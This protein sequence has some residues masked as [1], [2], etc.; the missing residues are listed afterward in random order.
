LLKDEIAI[1]DIINSNLYDRP[2]YWA[3][4]CQ[5]SKLMGLE[6]YLELE[7]LG[8]KL[9]VTQNPSDS[10]NY[11]IIGSG[12]INTDK[13]ADL[14]M[15]TWQWGN[16][17]K[18]DTHISS[19]YQPA[20]QSMQIVIM[21]TMEA[22]MAEGKT[23]EALAVGDKYFAAFPDMNFPFFYQTYLMLQPYFQANQLER[24]QPILEQLARNT[25]DRLDY[26]DTLDETRKRNS[27]EG[28]V[29][30]AEAIAR[31]MLQQVR[32]RGSEEIKASIEQIL[33]NH[34]YLVPEA[35]PQN[36]G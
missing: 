19:S 12:G 8:L 5:Q 28:E 25:A 35:G 21:R 11:G 23:N 29:V 34:L 10:R 17:D 18:V 31:G 32:A 9:T 13:T 2:I 6:N 30:R 3:V 26:Y 22:L 36:P 15:N 14:V 20:V 27:Y 24:A 4:T 16:F 33:G 1:L 7:G